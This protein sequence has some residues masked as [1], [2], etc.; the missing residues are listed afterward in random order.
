MK[1]TTVV[2]LSLLLVLSFLFSCSKKEGKPIARVGWFYTVTE[3]ELDSAIAN[4]PFSK[5]NACKTIEG[6]R[7][8]LEE[9]IR[10]EV[11]YRASKKMN[12]HRMPNIVEE[13]NKQKEK[14]INFLFAQEFI[15][16]NYGIPEVKI[17][18]YYR[19]NQD[20]FKNDSNTILP[21][22]KAKKAV[23][24]TMLLR[25]IDLQ[26]EFDKKK[27]SY[28][29]LK[30]QAEV[31]Q[32]FF[33]TKEKAKKAEQELSN[34][35]SFDI[36]VKKYN[37]DGKNKTDL[38]IVSYGDTLD[39]GIGYI[40]DF[41]KQVF[42]KKGVAGLER[43]E[44]TKVL[45]SNKG[46]HVF[47]VTKKIMP[48]DISLSDV[49]PELKKDVLKEYKEQFPQKYLE[50]LKEKYHVA[51]VETTQSPSEEE[52]KKFYET[53][54]Q[55]RDT[56]VSLD[57]AKAEIVEI[58]KER[59]EETFDSNFVFARGTKGIKI[60]KADLEELLKMAQP[61]VRS[62][63]RTEK[64]RARLIDILLKNELYNLEAE[65]TGFLRQKRMKEEIKEKTKGFY[66]YLV[67][68]NYL[69][70]D[71]GYSE[72]ELRDYYENDDKKYFYTRNG[73][74]KKGFGKVRKRVAQRILADARIELYYRLN[75]EQFS[76]D[77][78]KI[79][80]YE[81]VKDR[82]YRGFT[83][84]VPALRV[85][86]LYAELRKKAGVKIL[87]PKYESKELLTEKEKYDEVQRLLA[88]EKNQKKNKEKAG[89]LLDR[90]LDTYPDCKLGDEVCLT[91]AQLFISD[92][93][94][95]EAIWEYRK[96]LRLF[97]KSKHCDKSQFMIGYVY[98]E[99]I[100][101]QE[102]AKIAFRKV[103]DLYPK[104]DLADDAEF[105]IKNMGKDISEIIFQDEAL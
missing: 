94:F 49:L 48:R 57:S 23:I 98:S 27:E 54:F 85:K 6:K 21:F 30:A 95:R 88:E 45:Q 62:K 79:S 60:T 83:G 101:D 58:L 72:K 75:A 100:K 74:R 99:N 7:E 78:Y 89:E 5:R 16:T 52:I 103:I 47:Q 25:D 59:R 35:I 29:N 9:Y 10:T 41:D 104:S 55:N 56:T 11:L 73:K 39:H 33:S 76:T 34:G 19:K 28:T 69:D 97:P 15:Y 3:E 12:Y 82:V 1:R 64:G 70:R 36:L 51:I 66:A 40:R 44:H 20:V 14:W 46:F 86:E 8:Y 13:Y 18:K 24:D 32:L 26:A 87:D 38:G 105:M 63:Y 31:R 42:G 77:E 71:L 67:Q 91:K 17:R 80:P 37:A 92:K 61:H 84:K 96:L 90:I 81:E 53:R 68:S 93:K 2:T 22:E 50:R 4:L 102:K 43:G 65:A